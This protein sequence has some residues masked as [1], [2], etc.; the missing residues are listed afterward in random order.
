MDLELDWEEDI[1]WE[2]EAKKW[3]KEAEEDRKIREEYADW[4]FIN[5]Q[6]SPIKEALEILVETGDWYVA[7]AKADMTLGEINELRIK[8][9]IPIVS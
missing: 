6:P 7:A 1:D 9:N 8:A 3:K 4:N 2:S 5:K